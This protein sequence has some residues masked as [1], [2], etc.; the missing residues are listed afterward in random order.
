MSKILITAAL[1]YANGPIHF[2][3]LAGCYL[4][5]D[6]YAR[7]CRLKKE[8]ILFICG[9]DEYGVAIQLAAEIAKRSPEEHVAIFHALNKSLF[10]RL[11]ISF[12]HFS[13]TTWEGHKELAY[14]YFQD[15]LKNGF[16]EAK[17]SDQLFSEKDQ[18]FLA[19]R[20][21]VGGCPRCG[22]ENARGDE[23][24]R[25]GASYE[26]TDLINP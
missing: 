14:Q 19:D 26:A 20:Y 24:T 11:N 10:E 23:C 21:V 9:S 16:V 15:L 1:P 7:F 22:F 8:D 18:K 4:P 25:C 13:R 17:E 6:V 3:H 5:A 2:G 12:D